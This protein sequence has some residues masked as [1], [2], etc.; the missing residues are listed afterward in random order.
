MKGVDKV[1]P[2][3]RRYQAAIN[4]IRQADILRT[5]I[6]AGF[7]T[8]GNYKAITA[9]RHAYDGT[10]P[11]GVRSGYRGAHREDEL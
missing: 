4:L 5:T 2:A 1:T 11:R 8:E 9:A 10:K 6:R 7:P 3:L